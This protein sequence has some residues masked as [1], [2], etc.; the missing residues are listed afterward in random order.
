MKDLLKIVKF[1][2][3]LSKYYIIVGVFTI[4]LAILA[5]LQPLFT[6]G[7]V[8]QI[9][10]SLSGKH[11]DLFLVV[12]FAVLI[13]ITDVVITFLNDIS[14]Y[15]GDIL[16]IKLQA[17]LSQKYFKKLLSLPQTYFDLEKTGTIIN[18]MNRGIAQISSFVNVA[19]NNFLQ[20]IFS[21]VFTLIILFYFSWPVALIILLLYPIFIFL[22]L[23]TSKKWQGYQKIINN[24]EDEASGRFAEAIMQ[25]RA[26]K[27]FLREKTELKLFKKKYQTAIDNTYP[28]SKYW[29]TQ[30]I[31]RKTVLNIIFFLI[32]TLIF[33]Y[34]AKGFYNLGTLVL[35]IQ[36]VMMIRT[37]ISQISFLVDRTQRVISNAKDYFQVMDLDSDEEDNSSLELKISSGSIEFRQVSFSYHHTKPVLKNLSFELKPGSKTALV[38]ESGEGKTTITN[39]LLRFYELDSGEILIDQQ[40][41]AQVSRQSLRDKIGIVFQEP[42]LFSGTVKENLIYAKPDASQQEMIR[43]SV[44]ANADEFIKKLPKGYDSQ[45]GERGIQL[46][47]GQK[48]RIAI[49]RAILK[50]SP[51]L[52][53]DEATSSL[54]NKSEKI[55]QQAL[56]NLM[57]SKT[58]L[59]IA[60]RLSTIKSVDQIITLKNGQ[61]DEIGSPQDLSRTN[62]VYGQLLNLVATDNPTTEKKL[63]DFE[64]NKFE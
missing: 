13:F 12:L 11:V 56:Q 49:A 4:V 60:H 46:S 29:H 44:L 32:Y 33:I 19:A 62:G 43:A 40:N 54:D 10:N 28:Q 1:T 24:S 27:S 52:I 18:R 31:K 34:T 7:A 16:A 25:L 5:Q 21:T 15:F 35:L 23:R 37:P 20:F 36:Y 26:V 2:K 48:Q 39:L 45:I 58:T 6:K 14:G 22:T 63:K 51:I 42:A 41:I 3:E 55:I 47:G 30:D 59:I 57:K 38:G 50:D 53:L 64:I 61:I 17:N 8:D 9:T